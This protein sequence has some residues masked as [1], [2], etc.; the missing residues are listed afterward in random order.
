MAATVFVVDVFAYDLPVG[1]VEDLF[2][3]YFICMV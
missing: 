1:D 2:A 3:K